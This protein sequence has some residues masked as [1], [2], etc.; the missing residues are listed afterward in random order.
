MYSGHVPH[1]G[2]F[3][4]PVA[5]ASLSQEFSLHSISA[6][7]LSQPTVPAH[8][9]PPSQKP[10]T[11]ITNCD[12]YCR[13]LYLGNSARD[14]YNKLMSMLSTHNLSLWVHKSMILQQAHRSSC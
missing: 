7:R 13:V 12:D 3:P 4:E 2:Y 8:D 11:P 5:V 14:G 6:S 1:V 9:A 10:G